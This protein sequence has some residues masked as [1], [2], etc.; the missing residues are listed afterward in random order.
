MASSAYSGAKVVFCRHPNLKPND[1][2]PDPYCRGHLYDTREPAIFI[3]LTGQPLV[4]ATKY[5]QEVLRCLACQDRF[6]ASLP[7]DVEPKKY[8]ETCDVSLV[9]A[10]YG[11]G[12]PWNRLAQMQETFGVPLPASI[13]FER[14]EAVA[15]AALPVFLHFQSWRRTA[16]FF[17]AMIR[18]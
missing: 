7:K 6:T 18:E 2:C 9:I 10:T 17:I 14:C 11:A 5:Q 8:D 16:R 12:L 3:Q 1:R 13:Q 4:G 15:D